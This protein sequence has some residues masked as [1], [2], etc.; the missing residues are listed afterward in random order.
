MNYAVKTDRLT[1]AG[2]IYSDSSEKTVDADLSLPDY[3]P[4]IRK[5]LKCTLDPQIERKSVSGDRLV[6]SGSST[7]RVIYIDAIKNAVRCTEQCYPFEI[8]ASLPVAPQSAVISTET[9]VSYLNCRALSPRR[10][11]IHGAFTVGV[12]VIDKTDS[13]VCTHIKGNDIEQRKVPVEYSQL[14]ALV[15]QQFSVTEVLETDRSTPAVQS[16]I[17]C[18]VRAFTKDCK[19]SSGKISYKGE[20]SVKLLYLSDL[21]T[22]KTETLEYNIPFSQV[23][24]MQNT[25]EDGELAVRAEVMNSSVIL[26]TEIG[27]DDPLPVLSAGICVTVFSLSKRNEDIV[28]DCYSTSYKAKAVSAKTTV[29]LLI[30][31]LNE[32]IVE[33]SNVEFVDSSVS[34]VIDVWC[35]KGAAVCDC[36]NGKALLRGKYTICVLA[37]DPEGEVVYTERT[38]EYSRD[39]RAVENGVKLDTFV[40][41]EAVSVSFRIV[42]EK[43]IEVRT[44]LLVTGELYELKTINSITEVTADEN[45]R[46]VPGTDCSLILCY[47]KKGEDIWDIAR[48]HSASAERVRMENDL[49]EDILQSDMM[50]LLPV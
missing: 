16:V 37:S 41:G 20:L 19:L 13:R 49:S 9:R 14:N 35:E 22:G 17:R 25:A 6:I 11:N 29:P 8:S 48:E 10:L 5:I 28:T 18:D 36:V 15:W 26:K 40:S 46:T 32:S 23:I 12:K 3:C 4:D 21:D 7:V 31:S 33:R 30:S 24:G 42:S 2:V 43:R 1:T 34:G 44:E 50:I 27:F 47:A 45:D 39:L 38:M